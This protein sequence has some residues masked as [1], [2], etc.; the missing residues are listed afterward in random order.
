MKR[1]IVAVL[2]FA[3][4][5]ALGVGAVL[6]CA[7]EGVTADEGAGAAEHTADGQAEE[8]DGQT[9]RA[10]GQTEGVKE[11]E[12]ATEKAGVPEYGTGLGQIAARVE[13][14]KAGRVGERLTFAAEDFTR[15]FAVG[16]FDGV[17]ITSLPREEDGI[18]IH[19]GRRVKVGEYIK[20]K[21]IGSLIF[22][23]TG[24]E[25]TE[26][27]F[28]FVLDGAGLGVATVCRM[29]FGERANRPPSAEGEQLTV[30]AMAGVPTFFHISGS[31]PEG[32][33]LTVFIISPPR[34]GAARVVAGE[35]GR[36]ARIEY[37]PRADYTG[38]DEMRCVL[39]DGYGGYSAQVTVGIKIAPRIS[40]V[41][42]AD[43]TGRSEYAAAIAMSAVGVMNGRKQGGVSLF[44]PDGGV[45]RAE[46]VAMALTARGIRP[47]GVGIS[48]FED[49]RLIPRALVPYVAYAARCGIVD[50]DFGEGG[51]VFRP[52]DPITL[53]EAA[54]IM[55]RL[56]GVD[57]GS[58]N[59]TNPREEEIFG[60]YS[61]T[62][63][64]ATKADKNGTD[65][66]YGAIP[67]YATASV[68]AMITLGVFD[69][70]DGLFSADGIAADGS[71]IIAD[72]ALTRATVAE[73]L[74]RL[75]GLRG[76]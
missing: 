29:R 75:M 35:D 7:A 2:I 32:D 44:D 6:F 26:A 69:L 64:T 5:V 4:C 54:L 17:R 72:R 58:T 42:Y 12:G 71:V 63:F 62:P 28:E 46:F 20:R 61:G 16:D 36:A 14:I 55:A 1:F 22:V 52:N 31:D 48:F 51:L 37:T 43:M 60:E 76:Y 25:V 47:S 8:S 73:C 21:H 9:E 3:V 24:T 59:G 39:R 45:T 65:G 50:G 11:S 10:E 49:D 74:Y 19:A 53:S 38:T 15:A 70:N 40:E 41:V 57:G 33:P 13:V 68:Y 27:T 34:F 18:L 23:P 66:G 56:I 67:V 30:N